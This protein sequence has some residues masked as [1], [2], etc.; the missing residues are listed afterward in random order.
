MAVPSGGV[1]VED[2]LG[3]GV[4]PMLAEV[5]GDDGGEGED[6][7]PHEDWHVEGVSQLGNPSFFIRHTT[8]CSSW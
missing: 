8:L 4:E 7:D 3:V 1:G 2:E 6:C 5:E